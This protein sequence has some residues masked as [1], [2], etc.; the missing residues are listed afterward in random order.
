MASFTGSFAMSDAGQMAGAARTPLGENP[1]FQRRQL[2]QLP[3]AA[4][5]APALAQPTQTPFPQGTEGLE[6]R[7]LKTAL[8]R[9]GYDRATIEEF[10]K[11][12]NP[13]AT[14]DRPEGTSMLDA[15]SPIHG[16]RALR[17]GRPAIPGPAGMI[18]RLLGY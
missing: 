3:G 4:A 2:A 13:T 1:E 16:F 8:E 18:Q 6:G 10:L 11:R 15:L 12:A 14:Y 17:A 9:L 5:G 7:D